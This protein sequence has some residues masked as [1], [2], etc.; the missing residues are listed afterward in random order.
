MRI[1]ELRRK[2][3]YYEVVTETAVYE[4]DGRLLEQN[5][6]TAGGEAEETLLSELHEKSRRHRAMQRA[7][8]L[9]DDRDYSCLML[10]RKLM[11]TYQDKPLCQYVI[12]AL[13]Q[14][15]LLNDAR[16]AEKLAEYL[17]ERKHYG[18]FRAEQEMLHRGLDKTLT[19]DVLEQYADTAEENLPEVLEKKYGKVL[20]DPKD[21]R[22]REKVIAGMARLGYDYR[23]VKAAIADHFANETD[24]EDEA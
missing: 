12:A 4:I 3:S 17:V 23:S 11:Q 15:G 22:T 1:Q 10:Y 18:L 7:L 19:E 5:G 21:Y 24:E 2:R 6:M 8:Y 14:K 16:Y 13:V 20:T 9:L